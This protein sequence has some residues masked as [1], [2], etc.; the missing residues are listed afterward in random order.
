MNVYAAMEVAVN[1]EQAK[2]EILNVWRALP[3]EERSTET[4]AAQFAMAQYPNYLFRCKGDRFQVIKGWVTNDLS[5][6][7]KD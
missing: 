7:P 6:Y 5:H 4:Q 1:Q 3:P 2:A